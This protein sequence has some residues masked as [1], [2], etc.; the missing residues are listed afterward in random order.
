MTC[1][2]PKGAFYAMPKM[3]LPPGKT[4]RDYVLGLLRATGIL[5]VYGSGFGT[6]AADGFFRVVFLASPT[7]L[8]EIYD[9]TDPDLG[10]VVRG[11]D[12]SIVLPGVFPLHDLPDV[13]IELEHLSGDYTTVSGLVMARLG[14]VPAPGDV[15]VAD[16]WT[17]QVL[18]VAAHAVK[19]VAF[20]PAP[21]GDRQR[22][23]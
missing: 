1:V 17:I 10:T 18:D 20:L 4:D 9:E 16:G 21:D 3:T 12:G 8:G 6:D 19:R 15:T 13:G 14:R 5:V 22:E 23:A 11:D 2:A 7:E